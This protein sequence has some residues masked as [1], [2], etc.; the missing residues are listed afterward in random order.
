MCCSSWHPIAHVQELERKPESFRQLGMPGGQ[1]ILNSG[2]S[3]L[4]NPTRII[5]KSGNGAIGKPEASLD[6]S[7]QRANTPDNPSDWTDDGQTTV[8]QQRD[9]PLTHSTPSIAEAQ[10]DHRLVLGLPELG[11]DRR[12]VPSLDSESLHSSESSVIDR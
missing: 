12:Q 10:R 8:S 7:D 4:R 1:G 3:T 9:R 6:D 2:A 11:G 5:S